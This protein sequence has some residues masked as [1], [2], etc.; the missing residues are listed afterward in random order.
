MFI[1][2]YRKIFYTISIL[3]VVASIISLSVWGLKLGI[4]FKGGTSITFQYGAERPNIDAVK[5][6]IDTLSV[7]PSI[8]GTYSLVP[9]GQ[10]GYVLKTRNLSESERALIMGSIE[11]NTAEKVE[12]KKVNT[13]GPTLG[14]ASANKSLISIVLVLICIVL[15]ITFASGKF[16]NQFL[17][18]STVWSPSLHYVTM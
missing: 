13:I 8:S 2:K 12:F 11:S 1:V 18:G 14:Q 7:S 4:D 5:G 15:F 16:Q 3:L 9:Y 17:L 10:N 6:K